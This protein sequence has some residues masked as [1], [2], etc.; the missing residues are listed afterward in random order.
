VPSKEYDWIGIYKNSGKADTG[1]DCYYWV[2]GKTSPIITSIY[3]Q[4]GYQIRFFNGTGRRSYTRIA[5]TDPF[6]L[7]GVSSPAQ[8]CPRSPTDPEKSRLK[9]SFPLLRD[10]FQITDE[11]TGR[12]NCIAWSLGFTNRWINPGQPISNF[13]EQYRR[14]GCK[15]YE[16]LSPLASIDCWAKGDESTHGSKKYSL[17]GDLWESKCGSYFRI[18]HGREELKSPSYGEIFVS[19]GQPG[20]TTAD[21][22]N[23]ETYMINQMEKKQNTGGRCRCKC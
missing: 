4:E 16:K 10:D 19:F 2:A 12:Y 22:Q 9:K 17:P 23:M 14:S 3:V 5:V 1:Y 7:P 11:A 13:I 6:S 15:R 21:S 8:G 20:F 18:T